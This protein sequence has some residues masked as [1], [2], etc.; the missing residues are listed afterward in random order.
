[1][2]SGDGCAEFDVANGGPATALH[3]QRMLFS[4]SEPGRFRLET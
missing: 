4:D 3:P 1:V 2:G